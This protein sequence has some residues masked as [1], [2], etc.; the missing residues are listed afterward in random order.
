M[1][2]NLFQ[3]SLNNLRNHSSDFLAAAYVDILDAKM[4]RFVTK[5][6]SFG[7]VIICCRIMPKTAHGRRLKWLFDAKCH[8]ASRLGL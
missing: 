8:N 5:R 3:H 6:V 4:S 2:R 7:E 1:G